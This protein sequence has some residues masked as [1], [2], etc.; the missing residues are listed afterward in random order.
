MCPAFIPTT[1][2]VKPTWRPD[3]ANSQLTNSRKLWITTAWFGT[4]GQV[5][6]PDSGLRVAM[7]CRRKLRKAQM[8]T[9]PAL[10]LFRLTRTSSPCGR[11][12]TQRSPYCNKPSPNTANF[13]EQPATAITPARALIDAAGGIAR[14]PARGVS[15][16]VAPG[17]LASRGLSRRRHG[18]GQDRSS[19]RGHARAG[20]SRPLSRHRANVG[21]SQLGT[22]AD[23]FRPQSRDPTPWRGGR[24]G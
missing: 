18:P 11:T 7:H 9:P 13:Y 8:P 10:V 20:A 6:W 16:V 23:P 2:V 1:F 14:L 24:K 4:A 5:H 3:R 21:L 15:L 19:H 17:A 12:L 22:R